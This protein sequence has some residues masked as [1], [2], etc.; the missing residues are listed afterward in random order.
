MNKHWIR[1]FDAAK[2]AKQHSTAPKHSR[3]MGAALFSGSTLVSIGFNKYCY[4]HPESNVLSTA[5]HA[6]HVAILRRRHYSNKNL[7]MYVYRE[8]SKNRP[9]CSKPCKNCQTI[10]RDIGVKRV[11]YYSSDDEPKEMKL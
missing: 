5:T 1:G 2:S 9:V 7:I 11:R 10:L 8:D 4:S 3:K 6:E